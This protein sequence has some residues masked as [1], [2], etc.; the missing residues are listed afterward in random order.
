M[1]IGLCK[2]AGLKVIGS[3]GSDEKVAYLRD[4]L[5]VDVAFNYKKESTR[6]ILSANPFELY[7]DNV[8]GKSEISRR[9]CAKVWF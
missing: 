8:G 2:R 4:E 3:A 6:D 7:W 1:V 5:K 9:V